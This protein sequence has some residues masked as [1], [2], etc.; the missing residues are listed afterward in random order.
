[1]GLPCPCMG[2]AGFTLTGASRKS[3]RATESRSA[4][5]RTVPLAG[6]PPPPLGCFFDPGSKAVRP[7][8][9]DLSRRFRLVWRRPSVLGAVLSSG[10]QGAA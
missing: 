5:L 3:L 8:V 9:W 4:E 1:M 10:R 7:L 6:T 2:G